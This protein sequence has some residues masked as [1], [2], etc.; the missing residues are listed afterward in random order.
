MSKLKII[1]FSAT[2]CGPCKALKPN[3]EKLKASHK[4]IEFQ[5]I[6][7]DSNNQN[8]MD[9]IAKHGIR[10]VPTILFLKDEELQ[11]KTTGYKSLP[12]LKTLTKETLL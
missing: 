2:W 9:T 10:S 8:D 3:F 7:V 12:E 1:K 6:D 4:N 5:E 11:N